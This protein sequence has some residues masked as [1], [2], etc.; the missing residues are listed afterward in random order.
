MFEQDQILMIPGPT[1]VPEEARL[2]LAKHPTPH[3]SAEFSEILLSCCEKLKYVAQAEETEVFIYTASGTGAMEAALVNLLSPQDQV[4]AVVTGVFGKRWADM[5]EEFGANVSRIELQ[6]GQAVKPSQVENFL[7]QKSFK[8]ILLTHSETST[9]VL[10]PVK[11]IAE[12]AQKYGCLIA[13]DAITGLAAAELKTDQ[14]KLDLVIS[15]S[16]KGFM[17]P[18]G[19]SFLWA[20]PKAIEAYKK[21]TLP[22]FYWDWG[23]SLKALREGKTTAF[24]PN[25]SLICALEKTLNLMQKETIEKIVQRHQTLKNRL[26]VSLLAMGLK[27]LVE[28]DQNASPAITA[29]IKPEKIEIFQIREI[30][31]RKWNIIVAN[32]QRELKDKIFR[33]GHLGFVS[34]RNILTALNALAESL[35][36]LG[37]DLKPDWQALSRKSQEKELRSSIL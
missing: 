22:K 10:N 17:L 5:A 25:V 11:E 19:L 24:T 28:A 21:S 13:V 32:G 37:F 34:E 6:A 12:L 30:L 14:W 8:L 18:P 3:R 20:G 2:E 26:R 23:K 4:L 33:I 29:I 7:Q 27:L 1:P 9:G 36:E 31:K 35:L 15:G 16:Q